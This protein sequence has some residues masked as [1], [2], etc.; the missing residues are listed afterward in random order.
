MA[1]TNTSRRSRFKIQFFTAPANPASQSR[2]V[3]PHQPEIRHVSGDH[4]AGRDH[5]PAPNRDRQQGG[6]CAHAATLLQPGCRKLVR[7][8]FAPGPQ[9]VGERHAWPDK[10]IV[11]H[12]DAG[13]K[14]NAAFDGDAMS[15]TNA[16]FKKCMVAQ[17]AI[18]TDD[19]PGTDMGKGPDA[20]AVANNRAGINEGLRVNFHKI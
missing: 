2:R 8:F 14:I 3:A 10:N 4:G 16:I 18:I 11:F 9:I 5:G 19:S 1:A 20:G 13:P 6:V 12:R 15:Q 7:I 17:I